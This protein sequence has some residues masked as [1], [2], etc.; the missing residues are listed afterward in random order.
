MDEILILSD[1]RPGNYNQSIGLAEELEAKLKFGHKII[2]LNYNFW[3]ALPNF[4]I[5]ARIFNLTAESKQQLQALTH[6]PKLIIS[7]GRKTATAALFLKRKYPAAKIIQIMYPD[8]NLDYFDFV[9]L[10]KH[11]RISNHKNIILTIGAL[12]KS[13]SSAQ[14]KLQQL[15]TSLNDKAKIALIVGGDTKR[16]KFSERAAAKLAHDACKLAKKNN[17][18]LL[19]LTSPRTGKKLSD[20]LRAKLDCD[21]K[22]FDWE[23]V[24]NDNPYLAVLM[25]TDFFVVTGDSVSMISDCAATGKPVFIFNYENI[26]GP[27]DT[28]FH[29]NLFDEGYAQTLE[30]ALSSDSL[31]KLTNGKKL[32]ETKRVSKIIAEAVLS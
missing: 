9:L 16:R 3:S 24:K 29:Q 10:P 31:K 15:K 13:K 6:P 14:D 12:T 20:F 30:R 11:N 7:T 2:H 8:Y 18:Q 19:V 25:L 5:G 21:Y 22:F 4:L 32:L 26:A 28:L 23:E 1:G 17:A 27:K